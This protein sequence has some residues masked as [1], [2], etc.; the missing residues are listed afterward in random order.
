MLRLYRQFGE[1]MLVYLLFLQSKVT[2]QYVWDSI[3]REPGV[4]KNL[5]DEGG[6][7]NLLDHTQQEMT[8]VNSLKDE[9]RELYEQLSK[10]RVDLDLIDTIVSLLNLP[11]GTNQISH[12]TIDNLRKAILNPEEL[13]ALKK[14]LAKQ[15]MHCSNCQRLFGNGEML[16][17]AIGQG[18]RIYLYCAACKVP[19][20]RTCD[21]CTTGG[22][23]NLS[24]QVL[25]AIRKASVCPAC[26]NRK[27][28][29]APGHVAPAAAAGNEPAQPRGVFRVDWGRRLEPAVGRAVN[30]AHLVPVPAPPIFADDVNPALFRGVEHNFIAVDEVAP[31]QE[32][33]PDLLR[34]LRD[35]IAVE[36][37]REGEALRNRIMNEIDG[38][39]N[40]EGGRG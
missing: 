1:K 29:E 10:P 26:I 9:I 30:P 25:R 36:Q 31:V 2:P 33:I 22:R 27:M 14:D 17:S 15:E 11:Y 3:R 7:A 34:R 35:D 18:G 4:G 24:N 12:Q 37:L 5:L 20:F 13:A 40:V 39:D 6:L 19:E 8:E 32:N 21:H 28:S 16:T 23:V 38:I